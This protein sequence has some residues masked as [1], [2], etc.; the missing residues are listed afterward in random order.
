MN[1]W[2]K[3]LGSAVVAIAVAWSMLQQHDYRLNKLEA[4]FEQH[5]DKHEEQNNQMLKT[6]TQIQIDVSRLSA[7]ADEALRNK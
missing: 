3:M 7:K 4:S 6:L 2:I 1:E 5:L